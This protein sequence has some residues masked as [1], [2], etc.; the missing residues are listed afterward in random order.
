M[1]FVENGEARMFRGVECHKVG[2]IWECS[3]CSFRYGATRNDEK[4]A[5]RKERHSKH[6]Q[7]CALIVTF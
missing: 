1:E 3:A 6:Q 4:Q 5:E 7:W 2:R